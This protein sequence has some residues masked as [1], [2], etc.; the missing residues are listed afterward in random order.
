[1]NL[2]CYFDLLSSG[3]HRG[4]G[5]HVSFVR[6]TT[7]DTWNEQQKAMMKAGGNG[8]LKAFLLEHIGEE[9]KSMTIAQ[10]YN[11]KA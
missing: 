10:K 2:G 8:R 5:V 4:L 9:Y 6:S 7:M 1:M 11:T 3:Q